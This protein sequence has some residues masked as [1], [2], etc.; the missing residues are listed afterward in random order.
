VLLA[1]ALLLPWFLWGPGPFLDGA[2]RWFNDLNRF[3]RMKWQTEHTWADITGFSGLFWEW[4][5][6]R[7]LKPIQ[8]AGVLLVAGLY[9]LQGARPADL[10]RFATAAF[11]LFMLFNPVLWP[12]LYN[13]AL[14]TALLAVAGAGLLEPVPA[15]ARSWL[16]S[17]EAR[18]SR[19]KGYSE[20]LV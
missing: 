5:Q 14:V 4:G 2:V 3:P 19:E 10:G 15:G 20:P 12:Y 16:G 1:A 11:L 9:A 7:W 17:R 8:A 13:P 6:E 18:A